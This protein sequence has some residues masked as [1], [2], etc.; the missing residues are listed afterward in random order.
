MEYSSTVPRNL[1][2]AI[3]VKLMWKD[4]VQTD[5]EKDPLASGRESIL[6]CQQIKWSQKPQNEIS[7]FHMKA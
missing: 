4:G 7:V 2:L 6:P 5:G 1:W 3:T